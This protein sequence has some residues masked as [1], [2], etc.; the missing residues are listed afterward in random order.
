VR[1]HIPADF[2]IAVE[3]IPSAL[4]DRQKNAAVVGESKRLFQSNVIF[5]RWEVSILVHCAQLYIFFTCMRF[6]TFVVTT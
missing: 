6:K 3:T 1:S 4:L 2:A 5:G